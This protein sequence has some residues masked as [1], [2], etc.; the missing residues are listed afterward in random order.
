MTVQAY[1]ESDK[2]KV[3]QIVKLS[4]PK[5]DHN[6]ISQIGGNHAQHEQMF[7]ACTTKS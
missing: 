4:L 7:A 1:R 2:Q 6:P 3:K 5:N